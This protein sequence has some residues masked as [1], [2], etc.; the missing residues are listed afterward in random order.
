MQYIYGLFHPL[1]KELFYVG[2]THNIKQRLLTHIWCSKQSG[3]K[4]KNHSFI[5][6]LLK[7]KLKPLIEILDE[8]RE[9]EINELEQ[10]YIAYFKF[11]TIPLKNDQPGGDGQPKGFRFKN[12]HTAEKGIIPKQFIPYI[13]WAKGH[14]RSK[15]EIKKRVDALKA[16]GY[17]NLKARKALVATNL[18]TGEDILFDSLISASQTLKLSVPM[19]SNI[20]K[21]RRYVAKS[22]TFRYE[23]EMKRKKPKQQRRYIKILQTRLDGTGICYSSIVSAAKANKI[24]RDVIYSALKTNRLI[25]N[26][27]WSII[28]YAE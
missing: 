25:K 17:K 14:K 7:Q 13:G 18:Y 5:N 20:L 11:L 3:R 12:R 2:K 26:S 24:D 27:Y 10:F 21:K 8:A 1:T 22:Y 6:Y 23:G 9:N 4:N 16:R 28:N 15:E 19:I